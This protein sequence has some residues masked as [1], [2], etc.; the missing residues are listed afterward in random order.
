MPERELKLPRGYLSPSAVGAYLKCPYS[1][2]LKYIEGVKPL[3]ASDNLLLGS[4]AHAALETNNLN[5]INTGDDLPTAQVVS[6]FQD[7]LSQGIRKSLDEVCPPDW[8]TSEDDARETGA[9]CVE[10]YMTKKAKTI[11][12]KAVEVP[13]S[14]T[15]GGVPVQGK[16]DLIRSDAPPDQPEGR[17]AVADYKFV[18]KAK[19]SNEARMSVQLGV[20][21]E[22]TGLTDVEFISVVKTAKPKVETTPVSLLP[23]DLKRTANV[24]A[25]VANAISAG[26][27]PYTDPSS[28]ACCQKWCSEWHACPQGGKLRP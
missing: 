8:S 22:V 24:V 27:F 13:F 26:V 23:E 14:G 18:A 5:K 16:I 20:Y 21:A 9:A 10:Q 25:G 11:Y 2:Y 17:R 7:S 4:A 6:V 28:W 1:Y 19:S 3:V 15:V 12:P